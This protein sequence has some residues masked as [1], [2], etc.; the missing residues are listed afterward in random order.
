MA[1]GYHAPVEEYLE[2][3]IE[4]EEAG[5]PAMRA[6]LVERLGV[7][8]PAVSEMVARLE[9]DGYLSLDKQRV[10]QLSDSGRTFATA[11]MRRHRLAERLLT[12]L[13]GMPAW[14]VH[15]EACRLEHAI[16]GEVADLLVRKLGDPATC[17]HGNPIPGALTPAPVLALRP[18]ADVAVGTTVVVRRID[19]ELE[20]QLPRMKELY[21][22]GLVPGASLTV[23]TRQ[24]SSVDV[25][26]G[27]G[28]GATVTVMDAVAS[29]L[30]VSA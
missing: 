17:P 20:S 24:A 18:L 16:S 9:K 13:L 25:V 12:D 14:Q 2:T 15:E 19:E 7:S 26:V 5:I 29:Y 28:T 6:R 22:D 10:I 27:G 3:I 1:T 8:A 30:Y 21:D 4:L 23:L 11:V